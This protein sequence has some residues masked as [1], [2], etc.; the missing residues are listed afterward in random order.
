[1]P[2]EALEAWGWR[3]PFL[4]G[5]LVGLAGFFLRRHR[6]GTRRQ[7]RRQAARR[8]VETMR[9]HGRCSCGWPALS[10]FN[11]VGFYL[12]FVYIVSW[13]QLADDIA[14][15]HALEINSISMVVLLPIMVADGLAV[16]PLSA[17]RPLMLG[18]AALA[19]VGACRS[20]G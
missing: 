3:I 20:S 16:G 9:N 19:F 1:M 12:M 10:V 6:P 5:L 13:L 4:L 17:A 2:A 14:P 15:A 18:A 7:G 8:C 11:S